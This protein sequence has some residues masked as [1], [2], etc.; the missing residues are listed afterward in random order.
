MGVRVVVGV[1]VCGCSISISRIRGSRRLTPEMMY[2]PSLRQIYVHKQTPQHFPC[3]IFDLAC[4]GLTGSVINTSSQLG[5][6]G[7]SVCL[8]ASKYCYQ[9]KIGGTIKSVP[10]FGFEAIITDTYYHSFF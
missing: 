3:G 7:T 6:L 5:S 10:Y 4:G 9:H 1:Y 8:Q 2:V